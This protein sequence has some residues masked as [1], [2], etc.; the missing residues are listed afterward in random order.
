[1]IRLHGKFGDDAGIVCVKDSVGTTFW[2]V[3]LDVEQPENLRKAT[4]VQQLA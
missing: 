4:L 1:M 3:K 2:I